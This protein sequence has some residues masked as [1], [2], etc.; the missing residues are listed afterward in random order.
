MSKADPVG[1]HDLLFSFKLELQNIESYRRNGNFPTTFKMES[2]NNVY[3]LRTVL[4]FSI[5]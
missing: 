3:L 1:K 4:G 2:P 5:A